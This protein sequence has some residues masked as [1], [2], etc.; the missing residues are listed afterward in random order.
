VLVYGAG[1]D[2]A[3]DRPEA[4]ADMIDDFLQR[5]ERFIVSV[6]PSVLQP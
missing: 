5:Q 3:R 4:P 1:R 6:R 2:I